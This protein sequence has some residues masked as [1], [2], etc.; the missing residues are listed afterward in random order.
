MTCLIV[1]AALPVT[2]FLIA[3]DRKKLV[4]FSLIFAAG[5]ELIANA[6]GLI[7][8]D[9][10]FMTQA[11]STYRRFWTV[12]LFVLLFRQTSVFCGVDITQ[13]FF[14]FFYLP[15]IYTEW[16][17]YVHRLATIRLLLVTWKLFYRLKFFLADICCTDTRSTSCNFLGQQK[18]YRRAI[19]AASFLLD[20]FH[21]FFFWVSMIWKIHLC[22]WIV[23]V[24]TLSLMLSVYAKNLLLWRKQQTFVVVVVAPYQ[25]QF[26]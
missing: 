18:T 19:A 6:F 21:Q 22:R 9:K 1:W 15:S 11:Y 12:T 20:I 13:R 24:L 8:G 23:S 14:C 5:L 2:P 17:P 3:E 4:A 16:L 10:T 7:V 25:T 26:S